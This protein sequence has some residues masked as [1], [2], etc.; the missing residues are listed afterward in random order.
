MPR[1]EGQRRLSLVAFVSS[2]WL[3]ASRDYLKIQHNHVRGNKQ[4]VPRHVTV[5]P[6]HL[7]RCLHE[8][9][10]DRAC[11]AGMRYATCIMQHSML[12]RNVPPLFAGRLSPPPHLWAASQVPGRRL[13][14]DACPGRTAHGLY[15]HDDHSCPGLPPPPQALWG[16]MLLCALV[17]AKA[18]ELIMTA[19]KAS[20]YQSIFIEERK[21]GESLRS[22]AMFAS[23]LAGM[24][25]SFTTRELQSSVQNI[26]HYNIA[27]MDS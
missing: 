19:S 11:T 27:I 14:A 10:Y 7:H 25:G 15:F 22:G 18:K 1:L 12:Q 21:L 9:Q 16:A 3:M 26:T 13:G 5:L 8:S 20:C 4:R 24:D 23:W 2:V 17:L 6:R